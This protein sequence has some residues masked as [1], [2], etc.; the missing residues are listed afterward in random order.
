MTA[1]DRK[2]DAERRE[3]RRRADAYPILV[4]ALRSLADHYEPRPDVRARNGALIGTSDGS[5][6]ADLKS[7]AELLRELGEADR[8]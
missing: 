5:L 6:A 7:A 1:R 3:Q 2:I 4:E 8:A